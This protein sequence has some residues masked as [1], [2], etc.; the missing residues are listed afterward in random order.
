V[1]SFAV[2]PN[3]AIYKRYLEYLEK[4]ELN[5]GNLFAY[6]ATQAAYE[7]GEDWLNA[8]LKYIQGN[9]D[10]VSNFIEK[11]I[12]QIK[13][14]KPEASFLIWLDCRELGLSQKELVRLFTDKAHL[15]L[16]DGTMFGK[17]GEG[18][19]RMNVG[20]PRAVIE[21]AMNNLKN[22]IDK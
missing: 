19:M 11:N 17:E 20:S 5:Q 3:P 15:V 12:P 16:N 7:G 14:M 9:I 1:S 13:V 8:V 10:F 6:I 21:K 2:I 4:R 22:A 18:F